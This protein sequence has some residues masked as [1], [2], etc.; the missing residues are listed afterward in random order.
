MRRRPTRELLDTD[1]GTPSEVASSLR[2]LRWFNRWFGGISTS[3]RLIET[4]APGATRLSVLEVA[5]GDGFVPRALQKRLPQIDLQVTLLDRAQSHLNGNNSIRS[6]VADA[7]ALPFRDSTFDV[8]SSSL[9]VHHL[10]PDQVVLFAREALRVCRIAVLIN[11]LVRHRIHLAFAYAGVPLY[12]SRITRHDAPASVRQAYTVRE[13]RDLLEK[14][15]LGRVEIHSQY[16]FR[17]GA[18]VWKEQVS[19]P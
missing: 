7:L 8:V 14:A 15:G 11:D 3:L 17:M 19:A 2:D 1:S 6:L 5:A 12:R 18:V 16:F 10:H 4:V 13:M 9:F